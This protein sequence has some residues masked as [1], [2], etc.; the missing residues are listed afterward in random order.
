MNT[1]QNR[2]YR[3]RLQ[4]AVL[5]ACFVSATV[6]AEEARLGSVT[7]WATTVEDTESAAAF[8]PSLLR[9]S[10]NGG[11]DAAAPKLDFATGIEQRFMNGLSLDAGLSMTHATEID[12][13]GGTINYRDYF[14][15][16]RYGSLDTK[17]WY[18]PASPTSDQA[19]VYYEAGWLQPVGK[20]VS[21]S[22]RL[23]QY[24]PSNYAS[25][26]YDTAPSLS[27][28]ASTTVGGYGLGLRVI[29]G[30]GRMFGGEQDLHLMGSISKPLK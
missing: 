11:W 28:G 13:D 26:D 4:R 8:G 6:S 21:L 14:L 22:L 17:V 27:L 19:A 10:A 18:L 16:M 23:G 1:T 7:F 2:A 24:D 25:A 20:D 15:G 5:I 29:D 9:P 12:V 3:G 30:G